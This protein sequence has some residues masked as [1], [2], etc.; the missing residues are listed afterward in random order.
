MLVELLSNNTK[1]SACFEIYDDHHHDDSRCDIH[2][3]HSMV[4]VQ[5][6]I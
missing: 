2:P 6:V 5:S 1:A 4:I 3:L